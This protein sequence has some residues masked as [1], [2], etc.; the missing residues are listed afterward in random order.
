MARDLFA[1]AMLGQTVRISGSG[2]VSS[3]NGMTGEVVLDA[4]SVGALPA[5]TPIP[6][7]DGYAT[8][9]W[10]QEQG[11]LLSEDVQEITEQ[12]I[13]DIFGIQ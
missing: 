7:L 10:V 11:Y 12:E 5:D 9:V 4:E 13:D 2:A 8:E 3:V 6:V 1:K